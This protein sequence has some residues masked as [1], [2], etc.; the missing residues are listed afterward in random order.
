[1]CYYPPVT[2]IGIRELR[3][4]ASRYVELVKAGEVVEVTERGKLVALLVAPNPAMTSRD[5]LIAAGRVIPARAAL[6]LPKRRRVAVG[7]RAASRELE[8]LRE[9]RLE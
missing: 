8:E 4:H 5:R 2:R 1:M 3:Q 6:H 7:Q 9:E